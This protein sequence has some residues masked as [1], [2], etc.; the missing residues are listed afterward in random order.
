[1]RWSCLVLASLVAVACGGAGADPDASGEDVLGPLP[2][3]VPAQ[4][5]RL[6]T[7]AAAD[8]EAL[9]A[10]KPEVATALAR[11]RDLVGDGAAISYAGALEDEASNTVTFAE[12]SGAA[13][14]ATVAWAC[15]A[16]ACRALV[17][18]R[19]AGG[20]PQFTD[21]AGAATAAPVLAAP[22]LQML[23]PGNSFDEPPAVL[24]GALQG[25]D[26]PVV[27]V[28][29][30]RFVVASAWGQV[31][32]LDLSGLQA[33]A[34]ASGAYDEVESYPYVSAAT[35][36]RLMTELKEG[37]VLVWVGAGVAMKATSDGD[38]KTVGLTAARAV[39]GSETV[40]VGRVRALLDGNPFRDLAL[41]SLLVLAGG[42]TWGD[43]AWD[44]LT[45]DDAISPDSLL[46]NLQVGDHAVVAVAG[47][48]DARALEDGLGTLFDGL[49]A[50][51]PL[52]EAVN[53]ASSRLERM[54]L[55]ARW[56]R[57]PEA[58]ATDLTLPAAVADYWAT[59]PLKK[60]PAFAELNLR[61]ALNYT[62]LD[63]QS[64]VPY[65]PGALEDMVQN[66]YVREITGFDG[67]VFTKSWTYDS[68]GE[69]VTVQARLP[70]MVPGARFVLSA[71]GD[72]SGR[73]CDV[74]LYALA[75]VLEVTDGHIEGKGDYVEVR[76]TGNVDAST[77]LFPSDGT[78]VSG[79]ETCRLNASETTTEALS[80]NSEPS[81]IRL[82]H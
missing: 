48:L 40:H 62:C 2:H 49:F 58:P 76:F 55:A 13:G 34:E 29:L 74:Q 46:R 9:A 41:P 47:D 39:F 69:N 22:A 59:T 1:M 17:A 52:G 64:G 78:C 50:G 80:H 19:P 11:A 79:G 53:A 81:W 45:D 38:T 30:R 28:T 75:R 51:Q 25:D 71:R 82:F 77:F 18:T 42:R 14:T 32:D 72:V 15:A 12:V 24:T 27:D 5:S 33:A 20:E 68:K 3:E 35:L 23:L 4:V 43:G 37:D 54:G 8:V 6:E 44:P 66:L 67:P 56:K 73:M 21:G 16:E 31:F 36:D 61:V 10:Q 26:F 65:T 57:L 7:L 63:A 60:A 70:E